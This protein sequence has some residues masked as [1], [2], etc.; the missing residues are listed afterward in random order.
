MFDVLAKARSSPLLA[1]QLDWPKRLSMALDAAKVRLL[2]RYCLPVPLS[3]VLR[4]NRYD[5]TS[6]SAVGWCP[7]R[8]QVHFQWRDLS[9]QGV[10]YVKYV[11]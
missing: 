2:L 5:H 4:L 8:G 7:G 10:K 11:K 6:T 9:L 1:Q 3:A